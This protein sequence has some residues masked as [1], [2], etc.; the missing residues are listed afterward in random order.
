M[1][2]VRQRTEQSLG[3]LY[4]RS[5]DAI[6]IHPGVAGG[7]EPHPRTTAAAWCRRGAVCVEV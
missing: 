3:S 1:R 4:K 7:S 2:G 5:D 6:A